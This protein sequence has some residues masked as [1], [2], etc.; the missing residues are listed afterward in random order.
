MPREGG[1]HDVSITCEAAARRVN[2]QIMVSSPQRERVG[3]PA[4]SSVLAELAAVTRGR[5]GSIDELESIVQAVS[6]LP[7]AKEREERLR[8]WCH[9][10]WAGCI[11]ALLALYW[12]S[13]KLMGLI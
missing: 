8:L 5:A 1:S 6:L 9:P 10:L 13:R 7:E 2:T 12:V 4:R 11:V 3:R